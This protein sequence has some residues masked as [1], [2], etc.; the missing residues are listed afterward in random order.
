[1]GKRIL[2]SFLSIFLITLLVRSQVV[3]TLPAAFIESDLVT[4]TFD[5]TQG[6]A[7]LKDYTGDVYAHIGVITN[8]S[9]SNSDWKYVK[10][11]WSSNTAACLCVRQSTNTFTL[12]L[13]PNLRDYFGVPQGETI[14]KLALVFRSSDG[15][16]TGKAVGSTD[17]LIGLSG[18]EIPHDGVTYLSDTS[19]KLTLTAPN[20]STVH[21]I[22]SFNNWTADANSLMTKSG[23]KFT[24][25]ISGLTK[26]ME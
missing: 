26:G 14:Y 8:L 11:A 4:L 15:T 10:A 1:M 21:V 7:G 13:S 23:D 25:T 17:I 24:L 6:D 2:I 18:V 20:K 12:S 19:V 5:A 22:G 16:K 3:T 9:S